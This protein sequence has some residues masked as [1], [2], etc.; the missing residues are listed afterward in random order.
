[1]A[2][3]LPVEL[4]LAKSH[5]GPESIRPASSQLTRCGKKGSPPQRTSTAWLVSIVAPRRL[6]TGIQAGGVG[7]PFRTRPVYHE[8][9]DF[10]G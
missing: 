6:L 2:K 1:M 7:P 10:G 9:A 3:A 8:N 5:R 4:G